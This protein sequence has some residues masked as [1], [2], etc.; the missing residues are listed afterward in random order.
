MNPKGSD[1]DEER[2]AS[3]SERTGSREP[4]LVSIVTP[5]LNAASYLRATID[6]VLAQD[7]TPIEYILVDGGSTD[8]TLKIARSYGDRVRVL[9]IADSSQA[10][11]VNAGFRS[12]SGEF[13]TFLNADDTLYR[14]AIGAEVRALRSS[15]SSAYAYGE[16]VHVD[17]AGEV[18]GPYPTQPF[19]AAALALECFICQPATLIR[20]TA[21]ETIGCLRESWQTV[22]DYDLWLRFTRAGLEPVKVN[23]VLAASR[24]HGVSKTL[25]LRGLVFREIFALAQQEYGYV[26]FNWIHAYAGYSWNGKDTFGDNP[27]GSFGRTILTLIIGLA[28]NRRAPLRFIR[29][30]LHE[31]A[32]LRRIARRRSSP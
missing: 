10:R 29:E 26:P 16:A 31:V 30:F 12:S 13:F 17:A 20:A 6:S 14:S 21:F 3:S 1:F 27:T 28:E 24:M 9:V 4:G 22:F 8:D 25:R 5:T 19:S 23:A 18:L 32:R 15:P 2:R 7:Y 11:A